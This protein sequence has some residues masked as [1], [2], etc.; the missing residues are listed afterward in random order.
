M[1]FFSRQ[2]LDAL[3]MHEEMAW[4]LRIK[5]DETQFVE[6]GIKVW[7][8]LAMFKNSQEVFG[9]IEQRCS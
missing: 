3:L 2:S 8:R 4:L 1:L 6:G 7:H 9:S 5:S